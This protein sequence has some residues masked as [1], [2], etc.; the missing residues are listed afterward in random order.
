MACPNTSFTSSGIAFRSRFAEPT[1]FKGLR[2]G[3]GISGLCQYWHS[4][5]NGER[6]G[7]PGSSSSWHLWAL[8]STV[9]RRRR[10]R[11][12]LLSNDHDLIRRIHADLADSYDEE[13][14]LELDDR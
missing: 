4:G 11:T 9:S 10:R 14:E 6:R 5:V 2:G 8:A 13:L 12:A 3:F 1:H 7:D